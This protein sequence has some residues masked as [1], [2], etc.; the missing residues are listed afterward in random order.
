MPFFSTKTYGHEEGLSCAFRQWRA[1]HSHC[2]LVHGYALAF[3]FTFTAAQ[4]DERGWV[5]D[6]GGLK[7]LKAL[8][9]DTFDHVLAVAG[10][11]PH[12]ATFLTMHDQ[13]V[14]RVV[15]FPGGVGVE[16]FAKSAF[17]IAQDELSR[18]KMAPRVRVV[19][20]ECSE[21]GANSAIYMGDAPFDYGSTLDIQ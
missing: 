19:S 15:V 12:L 14:A 5:M 21:H 8:L 1:N 7:G 20:C 11:D 18:I 4:L 16:K 6:F 17:G 10:D 2:Q 13:G 9:K 3:K